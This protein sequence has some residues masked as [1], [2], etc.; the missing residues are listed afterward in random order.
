MKDATPNRWVTLD[1]EFKPDVNKID[2]HIETAICFNEAVLN[3]QM[4]SCYAL[5]AEEL[6]L[7]YS[8]GWVDGEFDFLVPG[9]IPENTA[10]RVFYGILFNQIGLRREKQR[11]MQALESLARTVQ[12]LDSTSKKSVSELTHVER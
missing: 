11:Q 4:A 1:H 6:N 3:A 7:P 8:Y 9:E 12:L 2:H 10:D 5:S